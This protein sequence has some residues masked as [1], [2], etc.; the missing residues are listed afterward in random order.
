MAYFLDLLLSLQNGVQMK[1]V[2]NDLKDAVTFSRG[3]VNTRGRV[4]QRLQNLIDVLIEQKTEAN[5]KPIS[6]S[7]M[8]SRK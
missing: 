7:P 5:Y 4:E 1:K 8:A 3:I 2:D 6:I